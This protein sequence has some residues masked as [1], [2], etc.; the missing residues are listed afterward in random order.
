MIDS[1]TKSF[2]S[3]KNFKKF[4]K[5]VISI[6]AFFLVLDQ[7]FAAS[8]ET[9]PNTSIFAKQATQDL[10]ETAVAQLI[11]N[12]RL[13]EKNIDKCLETEPSNDQCQFLKL[14]IENR[15]NPIADREPLEALRAKILDQDADLQFYKQVKELEK[16]IEIKNYSLARQLLDKLEKDYPDYPDLIMFKRNLNFLSSEADDEPTGLF[17]QSGSKAFEIYQ[18]RCESVDP[19]TIRK[20]IYDLD[21]CNRKQAL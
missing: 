8:R 14:N 10:Y 9:T 17:H 11:K 2:N 13:S 21:F 12:T 6:A 1:G 3:T 5:A 16:K 7:G 19:M 4:I 18:K 15:K 20:Y